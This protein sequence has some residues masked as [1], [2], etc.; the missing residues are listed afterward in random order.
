MN[1]AMMTEPFD[2]NRMADPSSAITLLR[3]GRNSELLI[4]ALRL[5]RQLEELSNRIEQVQ[6]SLSARR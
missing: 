6:T 1:A 2:Q 5:Q 3:A 4:E